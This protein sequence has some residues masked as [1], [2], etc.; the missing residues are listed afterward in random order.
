MKPSLTIV[1]LLLLALTAGCAAATANSDV[2]SAAEKGTKVAV[3]GGSYTNVDPK[4]LKQM[5]AQKNFFL[6]NVHIP[7]AGEI[8]KTDAFVPYDQI[9]ANIAKLPVDKSA[10]VLV[11]CSSGHMSGIAA[12]KLV[13]LG[14]T[15]VLNLSG[16][17]SA[18]QQ[19]G[20]SLLNK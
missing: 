4:T 2:P 8:E 19:Q 5:L 14:Y 6:V 20:F 7:Y 3:P 1:A 13:K 16:G 10:R 15:N 9:E 17:M 18:W 12:E 11:Y